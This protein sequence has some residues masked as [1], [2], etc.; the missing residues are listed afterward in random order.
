MQGGFKSEVQQAVKL[1]DQPPVGTEELA[2]GNDHFEIQLSFKAYSNNIVIDAKRYTATITP[3]WNAIFAAVAPTLINEA[4]D[5]S[6]RK[7]FQNF[8]ERESIKTFRKQKEFKDKTLTNFSFHKDEIET[9]MVQLRA[10]GLIKENDK[11]RS[12]K[13]TETYWIL[14][15]Y[16]NT[17]MVQLRA[18]RREPLP[19]DSDVGEVAEDDSLEDLL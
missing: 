1:R 11:K 14:T 13:D 18:I 9:C 3:S 4:S 8:F 12:V 10:L 2:Q 15:P 16:G 7:A 17:L 5:F 19:E 6:L